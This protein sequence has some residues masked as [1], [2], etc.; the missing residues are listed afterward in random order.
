MFKNEKDDKFVLFIIELFFYKY[1]FQVF[2]LLVD[3][4]LNSIFV[5]KKDYYVNF[6]FKCIW[7]CVYKKKKF[8]GDIS[9]YWLL[10]WKF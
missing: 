7:F 6:I 8:S 1:F 3:W 2:Y 4:I 5:I 9:N 10:N